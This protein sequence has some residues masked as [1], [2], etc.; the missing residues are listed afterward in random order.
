MGGTPA[1]GISAVAPTAPTIEAGTG[2]NDEAHAMSEDK[3]PFAMRDLTVAN[4]RCGSR[5]SFCPCWPMSAC[6][7]L[8]PQQRLAGRSHRAKSDISHRRKQ[9]A[10]Y[11]LRRTPWCTNRRYD[12]AVAGCMNIAAV[13]LQKHSHPIEFLGASRGSR[14]VDRKSESGGRLALP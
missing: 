1:N 10:F 4:G 3:Q 9:R 8:R 14:H 12:V 5:T 11:C 13:F 2:A 7:R 6:P